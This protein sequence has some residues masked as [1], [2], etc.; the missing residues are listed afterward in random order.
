M[1]ASEK[2]WNEAVTFKSLLRGELL[3]YEPLGGWTGVTYKITK[4]IGNTTYYDISSDN[5]KSE[6]NFNAKVKI[7]KYGEYTYISVKNGNKWID[8]ADYDWEC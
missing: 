2:K 6:I 8:F 7:E 5:G 1:K 4:K 3:G